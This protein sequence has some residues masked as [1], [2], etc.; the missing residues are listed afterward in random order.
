MVGAFPLGTFLVNLAGCFLIGLFA[1][2][3]LRNESD[4]KYL[5]IAGFCGG[6]TTF[7]TFSLENYNLWQ[8]QQY[9]MLALYVVSSLIVCLLAVGLGFRLSK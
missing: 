5:L 8:Q 7:S 9:G 3:F 2:Y 1:G 4:L 6:F